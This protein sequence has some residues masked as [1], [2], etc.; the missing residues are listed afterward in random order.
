VSG[1]P[2]LLPVPE[3]AAGTRLDRFL[4]EALPSYT[5]SAIRRFLDLGRVRVDGA[6]AAKAG[7]PLR[8][9]MVIEVDPP[10]PEPAPLLPESIP[11][12]VVFEDRDLAVVD[13]PAGLVVHPGHGNPT[14]TLVHALLGRGIALAP[15]GGA[16]RPGIVHR[17]DRETSGLLVVAKSDPAH[18]ALAR[19]FASRA[20]S[21]TYVA[22]V[23]G[24]PV[25]AEGRI[26]RAVGRS[27]ADRTR[28]SVHSPRGRAA[29]TLYRTRERLAGATLLE[30]DL[31]T[32]R[33]HQIRVHFSA[34]G[35]A[36]VGD[37][38]YGG[39]PWK[40]LRP[41]PVR[42]AL[43]ECRRIA[44]HA[45]RLALAHPITGKALEFRVPIPPDFDALVEAFRGRPR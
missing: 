16:L 4:A 35:H 36:V 6:R 38:R 10:S 20:V 22:L 5:R 8:P 29:T 23:W 11:I 3:E 39:S 14:G 30:V 15:A 1:D 40:S 13:K 9:G 21:K 24:R 45:E 28:M 31:V 37:A 33:T 25:P 27:R 26:D 17:L 2:V 7:L 41:G 42:D 18:R 32:G 34:I 44:L 43:R 12:E 19:A